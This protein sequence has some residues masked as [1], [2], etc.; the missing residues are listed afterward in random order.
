MEYQKVSKGSGGS[1][2]KMCF[3]RANLACGSQQPWQRERLAAA[4]GGLKATSG[5]QV[6][7]ITRRAA[8]AGKDLSCLGHVLLGHVAFY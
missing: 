7:T 2:M 1:A 8:N 6:S 5:T 4:L 3:L